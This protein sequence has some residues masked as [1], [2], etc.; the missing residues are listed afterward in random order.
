[1]AATCAWRSTSHAG[2]N[3]QHNQP[4]QNFFIAPSAAPLRLAQGVDPKPVLCFLQFKGNLNKSPPCLLIDGGAN[5]P[6]TIML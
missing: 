5:F 2:C 4:I 3:Q 6:P 1:M